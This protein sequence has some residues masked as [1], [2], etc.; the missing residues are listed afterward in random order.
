MEAAGQRRRHDAGPPNG[1]AS[2]LP[3]IRL[4]G[5]AANDSVNDSERALVGVFGA[6]QF[7]LAACVFGGPALV[8]G[9]SGQGRSNDSSDR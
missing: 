5:Q 6:K 8:S 9:C 7:Y 3:P 4:I 1:I 2:R